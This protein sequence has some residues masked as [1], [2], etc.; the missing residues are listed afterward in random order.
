MAECVHCD[1]RLAGFRSRA[2]RVLPRPLL[3]NPRRLTRATLRRPAL[4]AAGSKPSQAFGGR[5]RLHR[6]RLF[7]FAALCSPEIFSP[8]AHKPVAR[9]SIAATI[10]S[11]RRRHAVF[12][13]IVYDISYLLLRNR[14]QDNI[15]LFL[16]QWDDDSRREAP[17]CTL[18]AS[19][20][21]PLMD[22]KRTLQDRLDWQIL[23]LSGH[24][25]TSYHGQ[26]PGVIVAPI[27]P[28]S[29][30]EIAAH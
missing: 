20:A 18:H 25:E 14:R 11:S 17:R 9:V 23:T 24:S 8:F 16:I 28:E 13:C 1:A 3:P 21:W 4:R 6:E 15:V 29:R 10:R 22:P 19:L 27:T 2:G 26:E 7:T 5:Q 30:C 12:G